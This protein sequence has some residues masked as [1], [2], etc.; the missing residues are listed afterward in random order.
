M[1]PEQLKQH[2]RQIVIWKLEVNSVLLTSRYFCFTRL[3]GVSRTKTLALFL[4]AEVDRDL[5]SLLLEFWAGTKGLP[6]WNIPSGDFKTTRYLGA[7]QY[8][9][10]AETRKG[11]H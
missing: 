6:S 5:R 7:N 4:Y 8:R 10:R 3:L 2:V 9:I 1:T 11:S